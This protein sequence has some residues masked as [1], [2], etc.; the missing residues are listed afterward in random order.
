MMSVFATPMALSNARRGVPGCAPLGS[1]R[2]ARTSCRHMPAHR[3]QSWKPQRRGSVMKSKAKDSLES[4]RDQAA[5]DY[6]LGERAC[7]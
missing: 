7:G 3:V 4:L 1:C 2:P 6:E 5:R